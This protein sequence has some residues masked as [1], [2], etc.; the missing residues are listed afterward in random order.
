MI[1]SLLLAASVPHILINIEL[2]RGVRPWE[3]AAKYFGVEDTT[4]DPSQPESSQGGIA[5]L[6]GGS[7]RVIL[8]RFGDL[9]R[10][11]GTNKR[12]RSAT[13][14]L[15][16]T[17]PTQAKMDKA[18]DVLV[19]W[20]EGPAFVVNFGNLNADS[21]KAPSGTAT[22]R[23]RSGGPNPE[24]WKGLGASGLGETTAL[25]QARLTTL[26]DGRLSISGIESAIQRTYDSP[27]EVGGVALQ[28]S[29]SCEFYS[30]Q[31]PQFS[32]VLKLELEEVA[33][34]PSF[35]LSVS[36]I[37]RSPWPKP[38][39]APNEPAFPIQGDMIEHRAEIQNIGDLPCSGFRFRWKREGS[40][41]GWVQESSSIAP[42]AIKEAAI[43]IP[44]EQSKNSWLQDS[45]SF[46]VEAL[47]PEANRANNALEVPIAGLGIAIQISKEWKSDINPHRTA[48]ATD[49]AQALVRYFNRVVFPQSR[50]SFA[51][52]GTNERMYITGFESVSSN[53]ADFTMELLPDWESNVFRLAKLISSPLLDPKTDFLWAS[54]HDPFG[55]ITVRG[56]TR[57]DGA[58]PRTFFIPRE[59]IYH[60]LLSIAL[61]EPTN[62]LSMTDVYGLN[63]DVGKRGVQR[64]TYIQ[65]CPIAT[66]FKAL[67]MVGNPLI[68]AKISAFRFNGSGKQ[69]AEPFAK[70][71]T[72][73]T[74]GFQLPKQIVDGKPSSNPFGKVLL[75]GSNS[76]ILLQLESEHLAF[77]FIKSWQIV[78]LFARAGTNP[79]IF[80]VRFNTSDAPIET[81]NLAV[82]RIT[83]V[84]DNSQI[85]GF[86]TIPN[87]DK[88]TYRVLP[89]AVGS[90]V[91]IDLGRDRA[92]GEVLLH[93][94]PDE[95]WQE[96]EIVGYNTGQKPEEAVL[97]AKVKDSMR[98]ALFLG[99]FHSVVGRGVPFRAPAQRFRYI[100][101]R[102]LKAEL[103][104]AKLYDLKVFGVVQSKP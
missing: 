91:E 90:W 29:A 58:L 101:I 80:E 69:D 37:K 38:P 66:F 104:I 74:G 54:I 71:T 103:G 12:I 13:L 15:T 88:L 22:Y 9:R 45:L 46:E 70:L 14:L 28:F 41:G 59:P 92:I 82:N 47:Q 48:Y 76:I 23:W 98:T 81:T 89:G 32:P 64:G 78:D 60:P 11:I 31:S 7:G 16:P 83:T 25:P 20:H 65:N 51:P 24:S 57:F 97:W 67:D 100:R 96:F 49:M 3:S 95:F 84:S 77:S 34:I 68:G 75:D 8:I 79:A 36:C 21:G 93:Y 85:T 10:S 102:N 4:L 27:F 94:G 99:Y 53:S 50:F 56:E 19:E 40:W 72:D 26:D 17:S 55:S 62:L 73:S 18:S 35:D 52:G 5:F 63:Q 39:V 42:G 86:I 1:H 30:A 43:S 33:Q 87:R 61:P 2:S 6:K 44:F